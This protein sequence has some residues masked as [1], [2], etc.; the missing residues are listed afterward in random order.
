MNKIKMPTKRQK[1]ILEL[2]N[3]NELKN[4]LE[5]ISNR[6]DQSEERISK[7]KDKSFEILKS[8]ESKENK[9]KEK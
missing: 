7:L 2:K 1:Q 3:I 8:E 5:W 6:L 4:L 9:N